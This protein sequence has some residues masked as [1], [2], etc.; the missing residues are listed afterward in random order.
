MD[1]RKPLGVLQVSY[2]ENKTIGFVRI[3]IGD[4]LMATLHEH[5]DGLWYMPDGEVPAG[6]DIIGAVGFWLQHNGYIRP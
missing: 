2:Y 1:N 6:E 3:F 5:R 4:K